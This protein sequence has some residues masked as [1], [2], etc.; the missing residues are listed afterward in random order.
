MTRRSEAEVTLRRSLPRIEE[1]TNTRV[2]GSVSVRH[3][4]MDAIEA[5]LADEPIDEIILALP[6]HHLATRL[7]QEL[8]H[9]LTHWGL[10]VQTVSPD[11]EPASNPSQ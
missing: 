10:P 2:V 11:P 7:H 4:P 8:A 3:D 6:E 9:R 5:T 1:T